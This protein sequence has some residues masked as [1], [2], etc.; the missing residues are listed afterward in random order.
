MVASVTKEPVRSVHLEATSSS[1]ELL[2]DVTY[3]AALI[4]IS[5]RDQNGN[6]L[7]FCQEAIK[8]M[9]EG[10]IRIIGPEITALRGG[11]GGT[12]I[13]TTGAEGK[14]SLTITA[15]GVEPLRLTFTIRSGIREKERCDGR[16]I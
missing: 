15:E 14:A 1:T 13:R 7:P 4:R 12:L 16:Q 9:A 2:E 11:M 3:D 8:L 5:M 6:V 10:P